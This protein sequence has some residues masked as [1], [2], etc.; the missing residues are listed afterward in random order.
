[1]TDRKKALLFLVGLLGL[2]ILFYSRIL[3]TD[4]I[5]R[6]PDIIA[7]FYWGIKDMGSLSFRQLFPAS[8]QASWS[9]YVNSGYSVEGGDIS[10]SFLLWKNL[11]FWA[12]P[13]PAS[14]AWFIVLQLFFG[15]AGT[16]LCCRVIGASRLASFAGGMIFAL[17][18]EIASL[19]NAGHVMKIATISY[20]PWAF[21]FLERGFQSRRPIFFLTTALVLAFQFFNTH[22]QVAFY[23]CLC[24]G[25]YG[26][27]RL[28]G[29]AL[30]KKDDAKSP[31]LRLLGLN[32]ALLAFFLAT[33]SISLLP[34]ANW[35]KD[36][37]R[38]VQ[39]GSNQGGG[40]V[41]QGGLNVDEA[42]SW[43]LPPRNWPPSS[44]PGCLDSLARKRAKTRKTSPPITGGA[45][46]L[47]RPPITWGCCLGCSCRC[48]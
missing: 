18:P 11:V 2:L 22:W 24:V 40:A 35:S 16:Y 32:V 3:F 45:C 1:M 10:L 23:T 33:V 14:V 21:Y 30:A 44:S 6:A 41:L 15:G 48:R 36:T 37:N 8:L 43:S 25:A 46:D 26:V 28:I 4:K 42:M 20:A 29:I 31:L 39:S 17:S 47:P 34:L 13:A 27:F 5:I 38:G 12:I 9:P 7:E 19:I